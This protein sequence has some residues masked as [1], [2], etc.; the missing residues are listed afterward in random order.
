MGLTDLTD[1]ALIQRVLQEHPLH[2]DNEACTVLWQRHTSLVHTMLRSMVHAIPQGY[3]PQVFLAEAHQRAFENLLR[4]LAGY[5]GPDRFKAYLTRVVYSAALDELRVLTRRLAREQPSGDA[6]DTETR[7]MATSRTTAPDAWPFRSR[8]VSA[9]TQVARRERREI[10]R[11]ALH[12]HAQ[13]SHQ[14]LKSARAL[15]WRF[16][17]DWRITDIAARFRVD[18]RTVYRLLHDDLQELRQVLK[19]H[20]GIE[21]L[22]QI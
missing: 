12:L 19:R 6:H 2:G 3:D 5:R 1:D 7:Q 9:F 15:V 13:Q 21:H 14:H 20:F 11:A 22:S 4:R 17:M 16:R 8:Y 10:M 18:V